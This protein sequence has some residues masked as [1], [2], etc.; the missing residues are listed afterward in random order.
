MVTEDVCAACDFNRPGK[1]CLREME[2]L[3][4]GEHYAATS[5]DYIAIKAQLEAEK[6]PPRQDG[7][8]GDGPRYWADLSHEEQAAAKKTRLQMYSRKVYKRVLDKVSN[9]FPKS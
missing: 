4:R 8:G 9:A 6:F 7:F 2:W 1:T 5:S 3:W